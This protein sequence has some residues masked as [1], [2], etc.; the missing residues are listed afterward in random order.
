MAILTY[1]LLLGNKHSF[2]VITLLK[3]SERKRRN[4]KRYGESI[5]RGE[6]NRLCKVPERTGRRKCIKES[7]MNCIGRRGENMEDGRGKQVRKKE[8][9]QHREKERWMP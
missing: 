3:W 4:E 9:R 8:E 6:G 1:A 7:E 2:S 5:L